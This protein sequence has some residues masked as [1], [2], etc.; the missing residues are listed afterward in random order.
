MNQ[1]SEIDN[2]VQ[3][4][5]HEIRND[6]EWVNFKRSMVRAP[7]IIKQKVKVGH[8]LPA[9]EVFDSLNS[10]LQN[11]DQS[12]VF[13][14][15][16]VMRYT[17]YV[18]SYLNS[19][20]S[21]GEL[22]TRIF[23]PE[24]NSNNKPGFGVQDGNFELARDQECNIKL[25]FAIKYTDR[26]RMIKNDVYENLEYVINNI[27]LPLTRLNGLIKNIKRYIKEREFALLDVNRLYDDF[28]TL[29]SRDKTTL[30]LK[31]QQN[32]IRY[33]KNYELSKLKFEQIN[34]SLKNELPPFFELVCQFI[35]PLHGMFY[36]VQLS[37]NYS[38]FHILNK[39][40]ELQDKRSINKPELQAFAQAL[41]F[42]FHMKNK[43][44]KDLIEHMKITALTSI[45]YTD[46]IVRKN[47]E[48]DPI[49][50]T[51]TSNPSGMKSA[52]ILPNPSCPANDANQY[53]LARYNYQAQEDGDLSFKRGDRIEILDKKLQDWWKGK[54]EN[55]Q[56]GLFPKNYVEMEK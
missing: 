19:S 5:I 31:Q 12:V 28:Q 37:I 8:Q 50:L 16:E 6:S 25:N 7:Q 30:T 39:F 35:K 44:S 14:E 32:L 48:D 43:P 1:I 15:T 46:P 42:E 41:I 36:F 20:I 17:G 24:T 45:S 52:N 56:I 2:K 23:E 18:R 4:V 34:D 22:F 49:P 55:G 3:C 27:H 13:L 10:K 29:D 33:E 21:V 51:D 26:I 40:D 53:C 9:D 11:V 54:T 47:Q 38:F